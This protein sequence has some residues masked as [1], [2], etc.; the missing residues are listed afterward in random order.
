[1]SELTPQILLVDDD[2]DDHF[3]MQTVVKEFSP[4]I[5]VHSVYNGAQAMD[6]LLKG[7]DSPEENYT[8]DLILTDLNMPLLSGL[9]LLK[10]LKKNSK[11]CNI[12]VFIISTSKN[13]KIESEC[14]I[15]GALKYYLKPISTEDLKGI[16]SEVLLASGLGTV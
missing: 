8:P 4:E 11:L 10:E 16:I 13:D 3:F 9:E 12:P 14:L 5:K 6:L 1:M 15:H 7:E 2:P